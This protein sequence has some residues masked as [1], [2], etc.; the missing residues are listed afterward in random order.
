[1]EESSQIQGSDF[2]AEDDALLKQAERKLAAFMAENEEVFCCL[3]T[4]TLFLLDSVL[5][6]QVALVGEHPCRLQVLAA[7]DESE[8]LREAGD[9]IMSAYESDPIRLNFELLFLCKSIV[10]SDGSPE[11]WDAVAERIIARVQP[12]LEVSQRFSVEHGSV[13]YSMKNGTDNCVEERN[14]TSTAAQHRDEISSKGPAYLRYSCSRR[15]EPEKS[16]WVSSIFGALGISVPSSTLLG[17]RASKQ[18]VAPDAGLARQLVRLGFSLEASERALLQANNDEAAA[19]VYLTRAQE[20]P[21]DRGLAAQL[22]A[23]GFAPGRVRAALM[24]ANNDEVKALELLTGGELDGEEEEDG[25][26]FELIESAE[27]CLPPNS[28]DVLTTHI[29][30]QL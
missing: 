7:A 21:V 12:D 17:V 2:T 16:G 8:T 14:L 4:L 20:R 26:G 30:S 28:H 27:V 9:M 18:R 29:R 6:T 1:M 24:A 3:A 5:K 23:L 15:S 13:S 22:A 19:M 10:K 25:E 11:G